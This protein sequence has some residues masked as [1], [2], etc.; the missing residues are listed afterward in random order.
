MGRLSG[1]IGTGVKVSLNANPMDGSRY[2]RQNDK[3]VKDITLPL[4]MT[5]LIGDT[6]TVDC[7]TGNIFII[8]LTSN[9]LMNM[10]NVPSDEPYI[11]TF[12]IKNKGSFTLGF[13]DDI[14]FPDG[15]PPVITENGIDE[16]TITCYPDGTRLCSYTQNFTR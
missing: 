2:V 16:A 14:I 5:L 13:P 15:E 8:N 11:A 6:L 9:I 7:S 4:G 1:I 10:V 12:L 3:W